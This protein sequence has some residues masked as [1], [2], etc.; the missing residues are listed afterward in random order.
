MYYTFK[1]DP[2]PE[3]EYRH[4]TTLDHVYTRGW[5]VLLA[6]WVTSRFNHKTA[7]SVSSYLVAAF[8]DWSRIA[9]QQ[10]EAGVLRLNK[11]GFLGLINRARLKPTWKDMPKHLFMCALSDAESGCRTPVDSIKK[12]LSRRVSDEG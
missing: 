2:P 3:I 8:E 5:P 10:D 11:E 1:Y 9:R 4:I 6:A 12:Y 7:Y